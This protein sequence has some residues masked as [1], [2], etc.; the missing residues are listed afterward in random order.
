MAQPTD[1]ARYTLP[2][3]EISLT[4]PVKADSYDQMENRRGL[5]FRARLIINGTDVGTIENEGTGGPTTLFTT[6]EHRPAWKTLIAGARNRDGKP[7][8]EED[9]AN[10]LTTE[11]EFT[12]TIEKVRR[13]STEHAIRIISKHAIYSGGEPMIEYEE[14]VAATI[15]FP[16]AVT[17]TRENVPQLF[18]RVELP[19]DALRGD[20]WDG[21]QWLTFFSS[22]AQ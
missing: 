17:I 10:E 2:H 9:L 4:L 16:R 19:S 20:V 18:E 5:A 14:R 11:A 22:P 15:K 12:T 6:N 13:R 8:S 7:M 21:N 1:E 3:T